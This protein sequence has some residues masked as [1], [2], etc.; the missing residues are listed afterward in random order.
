MVSLH[1][2]L[3]PL[4]NTL[5]SLA[6]SHNL[7]PSAWQD[8]K[9]IT[10]MRLAISVVF[11][12]MAGYLLGA[13]TIN[14]ITVLLLA[15]GGYLMVG[16]SNAYNQIIEKDL[17]ALMDRTKNRPVAAGRMS[18]SRAFVI[19][20]VFTVLGLAV[21]YFINPITAV[22][23]AISIFLYVSVYTPLKTKTPLSVFVGA[24]PGA[25]PFMMG[26]IAATGNL[27]IEAGTLFMLQFF[28]Q[29]PHFWAIGWFLYDDYKKGGFFMLPTGK[30]D[31]G[32][33][34][35]V[36]LY[37]VW[38]ILVSLIPVFGV[39]GRLY[40]TPISAFLVG[41]LGLGLLYYAVRLYI[42]KNNLTAKRLM[43][44]SVSYITLIQIIYVADK[45][46]R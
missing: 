12:S 45:F 31:R 6:K 16:A 29:F 38:T 44:S 28:W 18:V 43:L 25:I 27:G 37:T 3:K 7:A 5:L 41:I 8:F 15:V 1:D 30:R 35:Q 22:F 19:A 20:T 13:Y 23:G 40:L 10:K 17:D 4:K 36:I 34:V 21:L 2:F 42:Y 46:L 33:A 9:E 24:F 11:S 14:W 39:T 26:W 32:T